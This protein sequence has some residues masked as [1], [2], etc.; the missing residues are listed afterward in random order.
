MELFNSYF[1]Y[2]K[3]DEILQDWFYEKSRIDNNEKL[4]LIYKGFDCIADKS[5][6]MLPSTNKSNLVKILESVNKILDFNG[7]INEDKE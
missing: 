4:V 1:S 5:A 7:K 6:D 3:P 2:G